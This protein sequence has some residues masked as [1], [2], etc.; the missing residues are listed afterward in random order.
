LKFLGPG[1]YLLNVST[2]VALAGRA[3]PG[4]DT[5]DVVAIVVMG[6]TTAGL[7]FILK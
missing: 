4:D 7:V 3:V 6:A 5:G 1:S 2:G